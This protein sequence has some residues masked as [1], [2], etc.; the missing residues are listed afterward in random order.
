M[1]EIIEWAQLNDKRKIE[2]KQTRTTSVNKEEQE[3]S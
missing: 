3:D 2:W 1:S